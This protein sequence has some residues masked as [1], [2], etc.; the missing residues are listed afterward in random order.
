MW[1]E[2]RQHWSTNNELKYVDSLADGSWKAW[3]EHPPQDISPE[4]L[5]SNFIRGAEYRAAHKTYGTV[6]AKAVIAA[7]RAHLERVRG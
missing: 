3:C 2:E 1:I 6:D 4:V 5:L 7:A